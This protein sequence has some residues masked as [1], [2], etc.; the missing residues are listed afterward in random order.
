MIIADKTSLILLLLLNLFS[1]DRAELNERHKIMLFQT[2]Y[3]FLLKK[4]MAQKFGKLEG[5]KKYNKILLKLID[6]RSIEFIGK[7]ILLSKY[8]EIY[9]LDSVLFTN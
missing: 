2:K 4:Y 1:P 6:I 8:F 7:S 9:F 5:E 3:S